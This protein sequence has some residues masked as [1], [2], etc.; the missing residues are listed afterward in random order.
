MTFDFSLVE[1]SDKI[2][3]VM[4]M[5]IDEVN[6]KLEPDLSKVIDLHHIQTL[7]PDSLLKYVQDQSVYYAEAVDQK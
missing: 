3:E 5:D 7:E 4:D 2:C 6:P 1:H